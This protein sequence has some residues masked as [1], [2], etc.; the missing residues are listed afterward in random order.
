MA[1]GYV[2]R[3][4]DPDDDYGPPAKRDSTNKMVEGEND[5]MQVDWL[6]TYATHQKACI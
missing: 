6:L 2:K 5:G 3:P 4:R 1:E